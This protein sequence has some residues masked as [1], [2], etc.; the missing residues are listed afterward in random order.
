VDYRVE[1]LP[2]PLPADQAEVLLGDHIRRWYCGE[3]GEGGLVG[4]TFSAHGWPTPWAALKPAT[5]REK[6]RLGYN[7]W[8]D[9]RRTGA[10]QDAAQ[11]PTIGRGPG[12]IVFIIY[13][14]QNN[15]AGPHQYGTAH[16]PARPP[17][18]QPTPE[19]CAGEAQQLA[20]VLFRARG[21]L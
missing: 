14:G 11:H 7:P 15:Y 17:L 8:Q 10:L 3:G 5:A 13:P 1:G 2:P 12:W 4:R 18:P 20:H 9:Q 16:M 6:A 21:W 19:D